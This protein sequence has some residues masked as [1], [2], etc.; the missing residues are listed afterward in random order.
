[1]C[2]LCCRDWSTTL[3]D[4]RASVLKELEPRP[5]LVPP[6]IWSPGE[7]NI[8]EDTF[9]VGHHDGG[10]TVG[11]GKR[12]QT[13]G[14][15]IGVEWIAIGGI[16]VIIDVTQ[17]ELVLHMGGCD[18]SVVLEFDA[19]LAVGDCDGQARAGHVLK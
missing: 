14:R 13:C 15:A 6:R 19:A 9:G 12:G 2:R 4:E 17:A 1:M 8:A 7:L 10:S 3:S 11:T 5:L 16:T 18:I